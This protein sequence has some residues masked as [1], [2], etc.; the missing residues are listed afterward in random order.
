VLSVI[1]S[2]LLPRVLHDA[3]ARVGLD[4]DLSQVSSGI[5]GFL[6]VLLMLLRPDGLLPERR[7]KRARPVVAEGEGFE[8][9]RH[10]AAP[11]GF[12]DRPIQPLSHPSEWP[13]LP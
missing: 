8:P 6:L 10:L 5:Y 11:N 7:R 3:P 12:R 13:G 9:S 1:D 4:F 2:Y